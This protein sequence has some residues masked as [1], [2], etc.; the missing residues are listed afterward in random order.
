M[1]YELDGSK[2]NDL[3]DRRNLLVDKLSGIVDVKTFEDSDGRFRLSIGGRL[4]VNHGYNQL[5]LVERTVQ[6]PKKN[7]DV[8]A[9]GLYESNVGR[10]RRL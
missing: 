8:D 5:K 3:R 7:P 6:A 2:Q 9:E 1:K 4:L 10:R